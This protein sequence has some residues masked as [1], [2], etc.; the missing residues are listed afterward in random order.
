[1]RDEYAIPVQQTFNDVELPNT[2]IKK[3]SLPIPN[4]FTPFFVHHEMI[5]E[6]VGRA[7]GCEFIHFAAPFEFYAYLKEDRL[8]LVQAKNAYLRA[9]LIL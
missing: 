4:I 8:F 5:I 7:K 9:S 6:Q 3:Q 2:T 1:M